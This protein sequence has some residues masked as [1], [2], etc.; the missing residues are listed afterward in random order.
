MEKKGYV[1]I[2]EID[3]LSGAI[4]RSLHAPQRQNEPEDEYNVYK[5]MWRLS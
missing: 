1:V 2:T 4:C 5:Y 3:E